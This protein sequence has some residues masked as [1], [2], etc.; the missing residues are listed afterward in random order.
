M[1]GTA[2]KLQECA[3]G[4]KLAINVQGREVDFWPNTREHESTSEKLAKE[5]KSKSSTLVPSRLLEVL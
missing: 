1:K 3:K 5:T 2:Q 4:R